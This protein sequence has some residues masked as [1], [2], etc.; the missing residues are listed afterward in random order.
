MAPGFLHSLN[1]GGFPPLPCPV[2]A[3]EQTKSGIYRD[4]DRAI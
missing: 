4:I 1:H 3:S 2:V